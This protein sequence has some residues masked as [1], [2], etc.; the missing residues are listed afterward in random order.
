MLKTFG[1]RPSLPVEKMQFVPL[2]GLCQ[3]KEVSHSKN[4]SQKCPTLNWGGCME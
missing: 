3:K 1:K 4:Q 2:K